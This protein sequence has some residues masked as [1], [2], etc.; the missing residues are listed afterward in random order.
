[1]IDPSGAYLVFKTYIHFVSFGFHNEI[2]QYRNATILLNPY[3][4][5]EL[6]EIN[7]P[8]ELDEINT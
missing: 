6:D 7:N 4:I 1:M 2:S 5:I 8:K 3:Y